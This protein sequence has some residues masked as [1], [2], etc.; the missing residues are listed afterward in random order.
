MC[1]FNTKEF[2]S[3]NNGEF[4]LSHFK[5]DDSYEWQRTGRERCGIILFY[6]RTEA[7]M[8]IEPRKGFEVCGILSNVYLSKKMNARG[9]IIAFV[10][11][12]NVRDKKIGINFEQC[13]VLAVQSVGE[14]NTL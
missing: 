5:T 7:T 6:E 10:R 12:Y 2:S 3:S 8:Y 13:L 11:F 4:E 14:H 9:K 1:N